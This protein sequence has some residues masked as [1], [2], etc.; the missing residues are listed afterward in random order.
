MFNFL[1]K[2]LESFERKDDW[3][4]EEEVIS[5]YYYQQQQCLNCL[6]FFSVTIPKGT[7]LKEFQFQTA[8]KDEIC[9]NCGCRGSLRLLGV[10]LH[11][12]NK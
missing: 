6:R 7:T 11:R 4:P 5:D 12:R 2:F 1:K 10:N 3:E 9:P 8:R